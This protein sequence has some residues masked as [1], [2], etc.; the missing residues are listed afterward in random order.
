VLLTFVPYDGLGRRGTIFTN[1]YQAAAS[2]VTPPNDFANAGNTS[3]TA[4]TVTNF[5]TMPASNLPTTIRTY[6]NGTPYGADVTRTAGASTNQSITYTDL[7]PAT[8]Y[9]WRYSGISSGAE[10][11][12]TTAFNTTTSAG[13][14]LATPIVNWNSWQSNDGGTIYFSVINTSDYPENTT[15]S[16]R[17]YDSSNV[18]IGTLIFV[19]GYTLYYSGTGGPDATFGYADVKASATNYT[20][21]AFS[22][23]VTWFNTNGPL[24]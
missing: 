9:T 14:T 6:L 12:L 13:P 17:I 15:F 5:I 18:Q 7:L 20:D 16:G 8:T 24:Q 1:R 21:S 3:V 10:S 2:P 11:N 4:T 19:S 22:S 23:L